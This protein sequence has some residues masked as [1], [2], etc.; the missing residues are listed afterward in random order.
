MLSE[1]PSKVSSAWRGK[2]RERWRRH[3]GG[4]DM[5]PAG[6]A[7]WC[8]SWLLSPPAVNHFPGFESRRGSCG[9][10][11]LKCSLPPLQPVAAHQRYA[12][13]CPN[14]E[15]GTQQT[16]FCQLES[17]QRLKEVDFYPRTFTASWLA[18]RSSDKARTGDKICLR[19]VTT[20][21]Q[22]HHQAYVADDSMTG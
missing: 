22:D 2:K 13:Y 4:T 16:K 1:T 9:W 10:I 15:L 3:G 7:R 5:S 18:E 6:A 20:T 21:A 17:K 19:Y 11:W 14:A 8:W 12:D